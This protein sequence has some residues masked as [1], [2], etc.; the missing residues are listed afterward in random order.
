MICPDWQYPHCGTFNSIQAFCTG[1][2]PFAPRSSMVRISLF[3]AE[4]IGVTHDLTAWPF[5]CTVHA[6]QSAMPHPNLV[7]VRARMSRPYHKRGMPGSPSKLRSIP[8]TLSLIIRI[9]FLRRWVFYDYPAPKPIGEKRE[10]ILVRPCR[11]CQR[12][13]GLQRQ[14]A[15]VLRWESSAIAEDS[16]ASG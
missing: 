1:C 13:S 10:W 5:L 16:A 4:L 15:W 6:P 11:P 14:L 2:R 12:R 7:P 8:F 3:A 9:P